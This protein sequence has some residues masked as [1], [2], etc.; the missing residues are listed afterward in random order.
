MLIGNVEVKVGENINKLKAG[1]S[2]HFNSGVKHDLVN[3]GKIDAEL[4]VV[5]YAP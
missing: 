2:L 3:S 1:D 4:V 5:V